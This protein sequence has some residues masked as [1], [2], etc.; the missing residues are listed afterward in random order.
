M[1]QENVWYNDKIYHLQRNLFDLA[2]SDGQHP[3]NRPLDSVCAQA[4]LIYCGHY[5]RDVPFSYPILANAVTRLKVAIEQYESAF[6]WN[7][8]RE[9]SKRMYWA[10]GFGGIAAEA[11][12]EYAW[13]VRRFA[14]IGKEMMVGSWA[15]SKMM[16]VEVLWQEELDE[17]GVRLWEQAQALGST[18]IPQSK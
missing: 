11:G 18:T 2:F 3:Q 13:F 7:T 14:E 10:L 12:A 15:E 8:D 9:D 5:L 4:G 17:A 1:P 6:V 16:F